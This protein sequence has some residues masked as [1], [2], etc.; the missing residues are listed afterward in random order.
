M[1]LPPLPDSFWISR[2]RQTNNLFHPGVYQ[3]GDV[4]A[5]S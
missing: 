4:Y 2:R 5:R 1:R 3:I